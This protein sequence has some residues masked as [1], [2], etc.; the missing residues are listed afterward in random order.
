MVPS[1][2]DQY[3]IIGCVRNP[4]IKSLNSI[5]DTISRVNRLIVIKPYIYIHSYSV[6]QLSYQLIS[7][8]LPSL[9]KSSD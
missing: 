1:C 8:L 5:M 3:F 4:E 6:D 9:C 7:Y 2:A